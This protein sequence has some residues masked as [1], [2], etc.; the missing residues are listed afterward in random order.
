MPNRE[1]QYR[2]RLTEDEHRALQEISRTLRVPISVFVRQAITAYAVVVDPDHAPADRVAVDYGSVR[3]LREQA[4][5]MTNLLKRLGDDQGE[6][7]DATLRLSDATDDPGERRC[8]ED[9]L[10]EVQEDLARLT[11]IAQ[12]ISGRLHKHMGEDRLLAVWGLRFMRID[13]LLPQA[14][15]YV[16]DDRPGVP[17]TV[18]DFELAR[19]HNLHEW[20]AEYSVASV[21]QGPEREPEGDDFP[22]E[23]E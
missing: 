22:D 17:Q 12:A 16:P 4:R 15:W 20:P 18:E 10:M 1:R 2:L 11:R 13:H 21:S 19:R 7:I 6:L 23:G 3:M 14:A 8:Y 9:A 5:D